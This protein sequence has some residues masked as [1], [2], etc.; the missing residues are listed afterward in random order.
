MILRAT[1]SES[2]GRRQIEVPFLWL[3]GKISMRSGIPR[4]VHAPDSISA[5]HDKSASYVDLKNLTLSNRKS[6][7]LQRQRT[8]KALCVGASGPCVLAFQ[9]SSIGSPYSFSVSRVA[10]MAAFVKERPIACAEAGSAQSST[11]AFE[12]VTIACSGQGRF[13]V[14]ECVCL[15]PDFSCV[16][17][18]PPAGFPRWRIFFIF[19]LKS[20]MFFFRDLSGKSSGEF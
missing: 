19:L 6:T 1:R 17:I 18:N 20:L 14:R 9:L 5:S 16:L 3:T 4:K 2:C 7:V 13:G 11:K 10:R 15:R 8:K 12:D